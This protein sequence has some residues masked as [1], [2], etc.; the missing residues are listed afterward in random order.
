MVLFSV[1]M[2]RP[3]TD[4]SVNRSGLVQIR[5]RSAPSA[6]RSGPL[7]PVA[8]A[9]RRSR[10]RSEAASLQQ[11]EDER[12]LREEAVSHHK[13]DEERRHKEEQEE[14]LA[15]AAAGQGGSNRR[16]LH[17]TPRSPCSR[18][19]CHSQQH[20]PWPALF[21]LSHCQRYLPRR[22]Q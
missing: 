10:F 4:Y 9:H 8:C 2:D 15:V 22:R 7:L 12:R 21:L 13:P 18:A 20:R 19:V 5:Y 16:V 6:I 14:E 11:E 17:E 1:W 3:V